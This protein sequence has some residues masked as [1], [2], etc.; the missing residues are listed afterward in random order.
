MDEF[1]MRPREPKGAEVRMVKYVA[2]AS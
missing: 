1:Q 2:K